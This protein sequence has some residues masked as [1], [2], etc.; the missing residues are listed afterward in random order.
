MTCLSVTRPANSPE[1]GDFSLENDTSVVLNY[2]VK[3]DSRAATSQDAIS[4]E[5]DGQS[6]P[7]FG[8]VY[9]G[10]V[11]LRKTPRRSEHDGRVWYVAC[12]FGVPKAGVEAAP[13]NPDPVNGERWA[14]DI[15]IRTVRNEREMQRDINGN[16]MV[17]SAGTPVTG[18]MTSFS[19]EEII[20]SFKT[21]VI[22]W[23]QIDQCYDA[24]GNGCVNAEDVTLIINGE[25]RVFAAGKLKYDD[26]ELAVTAKA[27]EPTYWNMKLNLRYR[28]A[29]WR[30]PAADKGL[31]RK[32]VDYVQPI[33]IRDAEGNTLQSP[34]YLDGAGDVLAEGE[35]VVLL[36]AGSGADAHQG[37]EVIGSADLGTLL[38][39]GLHT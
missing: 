17:N 36:P 12:H 38:L 3:F 11:C 20:L 35:Q 1:S 25:P 32:D 39:W 7:A 6:I 9:G 34:V 26:Y 27:G 30:F 14:I 19:D 33:P 31:Y 4:A 21:N 13:E 8:A 16:M 10:L 18:I 29:G 22:L 24:N 37:F 15:Q 5:A 28:F 23:D 2:M